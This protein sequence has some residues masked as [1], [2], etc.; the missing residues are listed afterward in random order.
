MQS[1]LSWASWTFK[2]QTVSNITTLN[3]S[4]PKLLLTTWEQLS[5]FVHEASWQNAKQT[6][7]ELT[8]THA[9]LEIPWNS[10][11]V[12]GTNEWQTLMIPCDLCWSPNMS[13]QLMKEREREREST[14]RCF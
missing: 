7:Q 6:D 13:E 11:L 4:C 12:L 9:G 14:D 5:L 8:Q 2:E 1:V 10:L 3:A